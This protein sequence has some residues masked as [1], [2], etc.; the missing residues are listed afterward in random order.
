MSAKF[1][2]ALRRGWLWVIS[3]GAGRSATRQVKRN[4]RTLTARSAQ[5]SFVQKLTNGGT[6]WSAPT[7]TNGMT[8][9]NGTTIGGKLPNTSAQQYVYAQGFYDSTT[10]SLLY[11]IGQGD[12]SSA[13]ILFQQFSPPDLIPG[14]RDPA[15]TKAGAT[16]HAAPGVHPRGGSGKS[17]GEQV[18]CQAP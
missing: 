10:S 17:S 5:L 13:D 8:A 15:L 6:S 1:Q 12:F 4:R 9:P 14:A 3:G 11:D 2:G 16:V 7:Y 18:V